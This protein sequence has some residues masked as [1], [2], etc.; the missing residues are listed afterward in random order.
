MRITVTSMR[1][2]LAVAGKASPVPVTAPAR[3]AMSQL[4]RVV[5]V[6]GPPAV[7]KTSVTRLIGRH[8]G[9]HVFR[10][11]EHVQAEA[12][13]TDPVRPG[14]FDGYTALSSVHAYLDAV[15][16]QGSVHTVLMD[17]FPG[18]HTQVSLFLSLARQ[19]A[20]AVT[21]SAVELVADAGVLWSRARARR[22]C[23]FCERD[24]AGDPHV[25][26]AA[27]AS[28]PSACARCGHQLTRRQDD[29][30]RACLARLSRYRDLA[31][32]VRTAFTDA[33]V[34]FRQ[35]DASDS[36]QAVERK[37]MLLLIPQGK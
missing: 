29:H 28:D 19:L 10:L 7:G 21:V 32:G 37:L 31:D 18:T 24:P 33:G 16:R 9:C 15:A 26:A 14:W 2:L 34:L 35:L 4:T 36:L 5:A 8:E 6:L 22:V 1:G 13:V 17:N 20:P 23:Q 12:T 11:R 30:P 27:S 3:G 25:P